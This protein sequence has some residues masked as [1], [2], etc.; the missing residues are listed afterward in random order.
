MTSFVSALGCNALKKPTVFTRVSAFNDW[1][2]E[3]SRQA[4][5]E[6]SRCC[7]S[8]RCSAGDIAGGRRVKIADPEEGLKGS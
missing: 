3:V 7:S 2:Q 5:Q 1:I 8:E 6:G 4:S